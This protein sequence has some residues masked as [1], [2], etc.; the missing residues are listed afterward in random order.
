MDPRS[1]LTSRRRFMKLLGLLGVGAP[2]LLRPRR[3]LAAGAEAL[4]AMAP[5]PPWP[6]MAYRQLGRTGVR[7][8]RLI[9]GCGAALSEGR[10]DALLNA[11]FEAGINVFDVGT[12]RYYEDAEKNL[13]PFLKKT[14]DEIFLISKGI[15][16]LEVK[17][18]EA[19]SLPQAKAAAADWLEMLERSLA[20]LGVEQ[21]DA[22]YVMAADNPSLVSSEE[23]VNAFLRARAGGKLRFFGLST[24]KN[25]QNVLEAA[26]ETGWYDL[27]M[28]AI[29]PAG[30]YDWDG[31]GVLEG[32]PSLAALQP[33]LARARGAG[34]GLIGMKAGRVLASRKWY[35]RANSKAFDRFYD[36][37]LLNA[38]LSDFQRSYAYVLEHGLDAVNADMQTESH[39]KE[40]FIAA[41]TSQRYFA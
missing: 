4:D 2:A 10:A 35:G 5:A 23:M 17:P 16:E 18:N 41:A 15:L 24:H 13:A 14:R 19:V 37:K 26:I 22:Y 6:K 12:R 36:E 20:E 38:E 34:M 29:T 27:A 8:S 31:W 9:F 30:W 3:L 40:N 21:V 39:L 28:L 7:V 11:A 33:L 1:S 32:T 25:A